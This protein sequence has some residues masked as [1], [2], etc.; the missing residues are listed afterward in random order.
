MDI[1]ELK[2]RAKEG[3]FV[4]QYELGCCYQDGLGVQ[5]DLDKAIYWYKESA[6]QGN[7]EAQIALED[8]GLN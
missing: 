7:Q 3:D 4:A 1:Y 5:K 2:K 6:S 8:I